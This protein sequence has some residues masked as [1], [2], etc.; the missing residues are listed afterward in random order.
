M[1]LILEDCE[2]ENESQI[3]NRILRVMTTN[4]LHAI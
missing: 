3:N 4:L 1:L 2:D